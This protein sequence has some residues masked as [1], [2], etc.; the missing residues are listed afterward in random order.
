MPPAIVKSGIDFVANVRGTQMELN[1]QSNSVSRYSLKTAEV[2]T[3]KEL[4]SVNNCV[5]EILCS[6][7]KGDE[8]T[9][10]AN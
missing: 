4:R 9:P 5:L 8:E 10:S 6:K 1:P 3:E 7:R 2:M